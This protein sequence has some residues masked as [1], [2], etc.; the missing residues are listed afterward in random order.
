MGLAVEPGQDRAAE[1]WRHAEN[2]DQLGIRD[3]ELVALLLDRFWSGLCHF[4]GSGKGIQW[5]GL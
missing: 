1:F 4:G 5:D 3:I 2:A